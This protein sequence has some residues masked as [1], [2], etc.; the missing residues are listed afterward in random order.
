MGNIEIAA[1]RPQDRESFDLEHSR[2]L[3]KANEELA[4]HLYWSRLRR[5]VRRESR[6]LPQ[7]S[8]ENTSAL[9]GTRP[10]LRPLVMA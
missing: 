1:V 9:R 7:D 2:D 8:D 5:V 6:A 3:L 4:G 10:E